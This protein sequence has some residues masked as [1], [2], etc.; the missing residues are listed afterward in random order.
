MGVFDTIKRVSQSV[1]RVTIDGSL[2][3]IL[4]SGG[5]KKGADAVIKQ[6]SI[7]SVN[8]DHGLVFFRD[9]RTGICPYP[10]FV[11]SD[12]MIYRINCSSNSS[13]GQINAFKGMTETEINSYFVKIFDMY[14]EID[15]SSKMNYQSYIALLRSLARKEGKTVRINNL[16]DFPIEELDSLNSKYCSGL[17]YT[18]NDRF[19]NSMRAEISGL[20]SYFYDFSINSAGRVL[21]GEKSIEQI[22]S[23]KP[24]IEVILDFA[25]NPEESTIILVAL[26]DSICRTDFSKASVSGVN[27]V[28]NGAPNSILINSGLQ[29]I[30]NNSNNCKVLF[31]VQDISNLAETSNEWIDIVDSYF[32]FRQSSNSNK[33]FCSLFFGEYEKKKES[34]TKSNSSPS[35][36]DILNGSSNNSSRQKSTT[37]T[38]EKER[39]Y[40]PEVFATLPENRAV[41]YNKR[42]NEHTYLNVF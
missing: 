31:D 36:W 20:E 15:K 32:F 21:S 18:R 13:N 7:D 41:F 5:S 6:F 2:G 17:E 12:Q 35:F 33:E 14:N 9:C 40:P 28:V 37:V 39:V 16:S 10:S 4:I 23:A 30:I 8:N 11:P 19:L 38:K 26:I 24:I 25:G 3:N 34:V 42:K 1:K 27:T 22:L 29:K